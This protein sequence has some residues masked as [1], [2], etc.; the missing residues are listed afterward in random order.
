MKI[1]VCGMKLRENIAAIDRLQPDYLGFIFFEGSKR[2]VKGTLAPGDL[3]STSAK[4]AG[5][6]VDQ[7]AEEVEAAVKEYNLHAVQL[8]GNE[9]P[10][11][12]R[13]FKRMGIEVIKAFSIE[14]GLDL[15]LARS[16]AD[17]CDLFLF[18]AKGKEAGGNGISFDW[19]VL[20]KYDSHVPFFLSGG[21]GPENISDVMKIKDARLFG[22][23]I[24][25]KAEHSPGIKDPAKVEQMISI[26]KSNKQLST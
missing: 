2:C 1:K 12:C 3:E 13:Y 10:G 20:E 11:E 17:C 8:H 5:V 25:S 4:R 14:K 23:D 26:I 16:Y 7:R 24:N 15:L 19:R 21:I 9:S 18:D 22:I 6:F